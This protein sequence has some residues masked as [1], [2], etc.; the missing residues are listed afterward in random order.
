MDDSEYGANAGA[1]K[2]AG[3]ILRL[4]SGGGDLFAGLL[5][6]DAVVIFAVL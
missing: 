6:L 3:A 5:S 1:V 4:G 2:A